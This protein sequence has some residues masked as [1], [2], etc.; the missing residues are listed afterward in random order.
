MAV[1][2]RR[3]TCR[4]CGE[5]VTIIRG[6]RGPLPERCDPCREEHERAK[7]REYV[8]ALRDRRRNELA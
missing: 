4:D 8:Q 7:N 6:E 1:K 5:R 2:E 3:I